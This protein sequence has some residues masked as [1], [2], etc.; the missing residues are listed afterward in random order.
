[1]GRWR[2]PAITRTAIQRTT[3]SGRSQVPEVGAIRYCLAVCFSTLLQEV[4]LDFVDDSQANDTTSDPLQS[5]KS[6]P[7]SSKDPNS[8]NVSQ[9]LAD[10]QHAVSQNARRLSQCKLLQGADSR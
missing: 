6:C 5:S 3:R 10:A 1:M 9:H 2:Q 8:N 7:A 4:W